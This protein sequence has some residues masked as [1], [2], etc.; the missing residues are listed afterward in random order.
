MSQTCRKE[1]KSVELEPMQKN[2]RDSIQKKYPL[3]GHGIPRLCSD[4]MRSLLFYAFKGNGLVLNFKLIYWKQIFAKI[5]LIKSNA[6]RNFLPFI[7]NEII[8][9]IN[10]MHCQD[11]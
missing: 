11:V 2:L 4:D 7:I 10:A 5:I 3:P 9:T 6:Q 8:T 1:Q